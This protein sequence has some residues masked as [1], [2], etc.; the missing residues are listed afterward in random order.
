MLKVFSFSPF[1]G[2]GSA[3]ERVK[4]ESENSIEERVPSL[5]FSAKGFESPAA[6]LTISNLPGNGGERAGGPEGV[7]TNEARGE[8]KTVAR[9]S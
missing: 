1:A 4:S 9:G 6:W 2:E 8:R 3:E 5:I 7:A